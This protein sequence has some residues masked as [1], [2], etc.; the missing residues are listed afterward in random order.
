M[1]YPRISSR[2][3]VPTYVTNKLLE[4]ANQ[5]ACQDIQLSA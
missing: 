3:T 4:I 5:L 1:D 2:N